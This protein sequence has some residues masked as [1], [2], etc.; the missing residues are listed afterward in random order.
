MDT[1]Q[2]YVKARDN[3]GLRDSYIA[4]AAGISQ[5]T[6]TDWKNGKSKPKVNK[7]KKIADA[8]NVSVDFLLTGD[9]TAPPPYSKEEM[10]LIDNYR[11]LNSKGREKV[12][13]YCSDLVDSGNYVK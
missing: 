10:S 5:S 1:Y 8:M 6:F 11:K 12:A 4:K 13:G 3:K 7:L 2:N 9:K